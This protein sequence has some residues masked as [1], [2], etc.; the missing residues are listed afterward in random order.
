MEEILDLMKQMELDQK[1]LKHELYKLCW[2]MRGSVSADEAFTM[3]IEDRE[4]IGKIIAENLET[5]KN[6]NLPFY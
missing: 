5:T 1:N 4:I 2:Y 6:T 3:C